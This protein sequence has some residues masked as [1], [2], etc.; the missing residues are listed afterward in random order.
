MNQTLPEDK[1]HLQNVLPKQLSPKQGQIKTSSKK[2]RSPIQKPKG[3]KLG[4]LEKNT[5][6]PKKTTGG[7]K[8]TVQFRNKHLTTPRRGRS[9]AK[10]SEREAG[11]RN[12]LRDKE[13]EMNMPL[14]Q[15]SETSR[16][17]VKTTGGRTEKKKRQEFQA[18]Q[19]E[20]NPEEQKDKRVRLEDGID[21][22]EDFEDAEGEDLTPALVFD[23]QV[24]WSQTFKVNHL[25][26]QEHRSDWID[27]RC[28]VSG[29]LL[30]SSRETL[31]LVQAFMEQLD[32]KHPGYGLFCFPNLQH[33]SH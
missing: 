20:N 8:E 31:P 24:N 12:H 17:R 16:L 9:S 27:L 28:N 7:K 25:D 30:L 18:G 23:T 1:E 21:S 33:L 11:V 14:Q 32:K 29:N 19:E 22:L 13:I 26:L 10:L 15:D 2:K 5:T 3:S 6:V 4:P